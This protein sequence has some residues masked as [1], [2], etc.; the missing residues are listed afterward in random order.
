ME[1]G[2]RYHGTSVRGEWERAK[3]RVILGCSEAAAGLCVKIGARSMT[4]MDG[5]AIRDDVPT[6]P[7]YS[8]ILGSTRT[9]SPFIPL[10]GSRVQ[11]KTT[12]SKVHLL[13]FARITTT[14]LEGTCTHQLLASPCQPAADAPMHQR[15]LRS[16]PFAP[17]LPDGFHVPLCLAL[18]RKRKDLVQ[19][20]GAEQ[21]EAGRWIH[22]SWDRKLESRR[23]SLI[24]RCE[25]GECG[26]V[27]D[28]VIS[29]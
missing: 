3:L 27:K 23:S 17:R 9:R 22:C 25:C 21:G 24:Y 15:M 11:G 26:N 20:G 14:H 18:Q 8:S 10:L 19:T 4:L 1:N 16:T 6:N 29:F 2:L 7:Y 28:L 13:G 12:T 5:A